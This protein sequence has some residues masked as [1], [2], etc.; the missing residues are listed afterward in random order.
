M[1]NPDWF[2]YSLKQVSGV[3]EY[4]PVWKNFTVTPPLA[5]NALIGTT[6]VTIS[7]T[8]ADEGPDGTLSYTIDS[9]STSKLNRFN[10]ILLF[11]ET[12][13]LV[14]QTKELSADN[15]LSKINVFLLG[16]HIS[17]RTFLYEVAVLI[18]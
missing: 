6:V 17:K 9:I 3:N 11:K 1:P 4:D 8:D 5:E 13:L 14:H 16:M 7:A 10:L 15:G 2:D 18:S 12:D